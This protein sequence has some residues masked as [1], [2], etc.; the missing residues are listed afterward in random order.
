VESWVS[1]FN[2]TPRPPPRSFR[3]GERM[4]GVGYLVGFGWLGDIVA[5]GSVLEEGCG[6]GILISSK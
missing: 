2:P 5:E 4:G 6:H 3:E 1:H